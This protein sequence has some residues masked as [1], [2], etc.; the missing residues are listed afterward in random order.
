M[1][2]Q[3]LTFLVE[4]ICGFFAFA[5]LLRFY[6]QWA[7]A[8]QRNPLSDFLGA[9]TNWA[10]IPARRIIPGLWGID[11][12]TLLL[13]WLVQS[14]QTALTLALKGFEFSPAGGAILAV[15]AIAAVALVKLLVYVLMFALIGQAVI[16]WVNPYSPFAPLLTAMTRPVLRPLQKRIPLVGN[17]DLSP[18]IAIVVLQ[19]ILMVPV[20]ILEVSATRLL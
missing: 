9:L 8:A 13:A 18:L 2:A 15:L 4:T 6:L 20:S 1:L 11:L 17:V 10:V 12:P 5:L 19:L 16:S 3:A 14:V 7:R